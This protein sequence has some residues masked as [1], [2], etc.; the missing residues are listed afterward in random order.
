MC[1]LFLACRAFRVVKNA[2]RL[3]HTA[4]IGG[5]DIKCA[6][7]AVHQ[8]HA[9][10]CRDHIR[11]GSFFALHPYNR[12]GLLRCWLLLRIRRLPELCKLIWH[13]RR[14]LLPHRI[15]VRHIAGLIRY[16]KRHSQSSFLPIIQWRFFAAVP[17]IKPIAVN[18]RD[19]V[20]CHSQNIYASRIVGGEIRNG[21]TVRAGVWQCVPLPAFPPQITA[22]NI[23]CRWHIMQ[24]IALKC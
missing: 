12:R 9:V 24:Q 4:G 2:Q 5:F 14:H 3:R 6:V 10:S 15:I 16:A 7:F 17:S 20:R 19:N 1:G 18:D 11:F 13:S 8:Q 21:V 22:P 23:I